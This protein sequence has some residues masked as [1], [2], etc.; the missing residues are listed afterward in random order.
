MATLAFLIGNWQAIVAL[1]LCLVV[2]GALAWFLKNWK[3]AAAAVALL[4]V[5]FAGQALWT[6]GYKARV[7]E[8]VAKQTK[9]LTERIETMNKVAEEEAKRAIEDA[10]KIAELEAKAN[11]TPANS[12]ACLDSDSAGRVRDIK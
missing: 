3:I 10:N 1:T 8:D 5:Y 11:E 7:A 4:V 12:G 6:A 2:L 9:I